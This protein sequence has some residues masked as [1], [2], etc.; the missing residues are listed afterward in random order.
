MRPIVSISSTSRP[1]NYT[2][3]ALAVVN[4]E[5]RKRD[6][7]VDLFD[8][9]DLTL[10]FPGEAPTEDAERLRAAVRA[11]SAVVL[12]TP[13]SHGGFAAMTKLIIENLGFPSALSDRPVALLGVAAGRIGAIESLEQLR[14]VC[15]HARRRGAGLTRWRRRSLPSTARDRP[16]AAAPWARRAS[17]ARTPRRASPPNRGSDPTS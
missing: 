10:S 16:R 17:R 11:A 4:D 3:R 8:A 13:E 7:E 15:S 6:V 5:L 9:R 12:A 1:D 2:S 14:G